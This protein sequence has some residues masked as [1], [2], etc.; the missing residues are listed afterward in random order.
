MAKDADE[1]MS[2]DRAR[3]SLLVIWMWGGGTVFLL[4]MVQSILGRYGD[5][6]QAV[7]SWFIPSIVPTISLMVGVLGVTA[8]AV[9]HN[10]PK[11]VKAFFFR[12]SRAFSVFYLCVLFFTIV[13]QPFGQL[14]AVDLYTISNYWLGPLQGLV[15]AALSVLFVSK[16][17]QQAGQPMPGANAGNPH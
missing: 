14:P 9:D 17:R 13:L 7:W 8:L 1:W 11:V 10:E 5:K 3:S 6:L 2:L 12:V 15:V 4:L 16:E